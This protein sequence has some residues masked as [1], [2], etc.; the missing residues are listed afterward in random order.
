MPA[1]LFAAAIPVA[2]LDTTAVA[3]LPGVVGRP[4]VWLR[5]AAA[6]GL[7][8]A[9]AVSIAGLARAEGIAAV[10]QSA[11]DALNRGEA[12]AALAGAREAAT[13]DPDLPPYAFT[14][15]V[16]ELAA[17]GA[18][19]APAGAGVDAAVLDAAADA[20]ARSAGV[21][22]LPQAWLDL[23]WVE[24]ARGNDDAAREAVDRAMRLG[25]QQPAVAYAAGSL[26]D[27]LGDDAAARDAWVTALVALPSLANDPPPDLGDQPDAESR[28]WPEIVD[29]AQAA[30]PGWTAWELALVGESEADALAL[31]ARTDDPD[32]AALVTRGWHGDEDAI[33]EVEALAEANPLSQGYIGWAARL[34]AHAGDLEAAEDYRRWGALVA[35]GASFIGYDARL[36]TPAEARADGARAGTS[37]TFHGHYV[38]RRPLAW[39]LLVGDLPRLAFE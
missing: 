20:L 12:G 26:L 4:P 37:A 14:L 2:L 35:G 31:A 34:N 10:E 19:A 21:D 9:A 39:D 18:E 16:A 3:R 11:V 22:D 25:V 28:R 5:R 30:A 29:E 27:R 38:Y 17:A 13:G 8:L 36:A 6:A 32:F 15:G 23:A 7:I 33:G 1:T 24:T